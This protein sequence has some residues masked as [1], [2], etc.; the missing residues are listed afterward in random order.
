MQNKKLVYWI[1]LTGPAA[2]DEIV[3]LT[4]I[5]TN[6]KVLF[7]HTFSTKL[8]DYWDSDIN[9]IIPE[10]TYKERP[11][12]NY[13]K[14]TYRINKLLTLLTISEYLAMMKIQL[15]IC[16]I[17]TGINYQKTFMIEKVSI[18]QEPLIIA[19][20]KWKNIVKHSKTKL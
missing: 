19:I 3:R 10:D 4:I 1:D 12:D 13:K 2:L 9:G 5:D 16:A 18:T 15:I 7:N 11:F 14:E 8:V 17:I 20:T 6:N